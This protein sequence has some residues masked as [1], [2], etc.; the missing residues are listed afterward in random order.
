MESLKWFFGFGRRTEDEDAQR[1]LIHLNRAVEAVKDRVKDVESTFLEDYVGNLLPLHGLDQSVQMTIAYLDENPDYP[2]TRRR[3]YMYYLYGHPRAGERDLIDDDEEEI[4]QG[5]SDED[6][7]ES[8]G[9]HESDPDRSDDG[10]SDDEFRPIPGNYDSDDDDDQ[11][12]DEQLIIEVPECGCCFGQIPAGDEI[13]LCPAK[14]TFCIQCLV[15]H[16][17]V[18][19]GEQKSILKCMHQSECDQSFTDHELRRYLPDKLIQLYDNLIQ[20]RDLVGA[21][22]P[23]LVR[24]PFCRYAC[25]LDMSVEEAPL[26][27]CHNVA[28]CGFIKEDGCNRMTCPTCRTSSCYVCRKAIVGDYEHFYDNLHNAPDGRCRLWDAQPLNE[29]HAQEV[30]AAYEEAVAQR[31]RAARPHPQEQARDAWNYEL[32]N[33]REEPAGRLAVARQPVRVEPE[34]QAAV[35]GWRRFVGANHR[36]NEREVRNAPAHAAPVLAVARDVRVIEQPQGLVRHANARP[37]PQEPV[38]DAWNYQAPIQQEEPAGRIV[39][40]RQPVRVEPEAQAAVVGWRRLAQA[41]RDRDNVRAVRNAPAPAAPVLAVPVARDI[42]AIEQPQAQALVRAPARPQPNLQ[43]LQLQQDITHAQHAAKLARR[44][45]TEALKRVQDVKAR[46]EAYYRQLRRGDDVHPPHVRC[47][48]YRPGQ[49]CI[50]RTYEGYNPTPER[51]AREA[52]Y[53]FAVGEVERYEQESEEAG[54]RWREAR[55]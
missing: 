10:V 29:I 55:G 24:C 40:A 42:Q 31:A 15:A 37:P 44:R 52:H 21:N 27:Q 12:G 25:V 23:G 22:I 33:Q 50:R 11:E 38:R 41:N 36:E 49:K 8:L 53:K 45:E 2:K 6:D 54:R 48:H 19:F 17:S 4:V 34:A 20:E 28:E 7:G 14:H 30:H 46:E 9:G 51:E 39:V 26:F 16:A 5:D 1:N 3:I 35:V 47:F 32:P 13:A 18:Q 43:Q